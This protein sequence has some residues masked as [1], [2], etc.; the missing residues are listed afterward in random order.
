MP[1]IAIIQARMGSTRF[2]GKSM[3]TI[4]G[5]PILSYLKDQL[6]H[7]RLI[8]KVVLAAPDTPDNDEMCIFGQ[9]LGWTVFRGSESDVLA[10]YYLAG[11]A[12]GADETW[13]VVRLTGDDILP[14]PYLIDAIANLYLSFGGTYDYIAT[15][16]ER[17]LPYGAGVE[18]MSFAAL[19]RAFHEAT[20]EHEREHV[21]PYIKWNP[22]KFRILELHSHIDLSKSVSLSIDTP[23][24]LD[25]NILLIERLQQRGRAP[26]HLNDILVA[27]RDIES[28][29][30]SFPPS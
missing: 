20:T 24:D 8:N 28:A 16:R 26:F 14:D 7:A 30:L 18:I 4:L 1:I 17:R 15:D 6:D 21:V 12:T 29:G 2:P 13:G 19:K 23:E 11:L 10:R 27:A 5:R 25:R 22:E 3:A 9:A